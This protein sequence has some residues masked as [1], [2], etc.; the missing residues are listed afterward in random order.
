MGAKFLTLTGCL[1]LS[2][3][4]AIAAG[5]GDC[6]KISNA[7]DRLAAPGSFFLLLPGVVP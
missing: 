6:T 5:P 3:Q 2:V 7:S 1:L 4:A